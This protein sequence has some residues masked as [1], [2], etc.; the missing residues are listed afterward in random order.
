MPV[1]STNA[2]G[3]S[4]WAIDDPVVRLREWGGTRAIEL[5]AL[6]VQ[7]VVGAAP[8]C[9]VVL[10][11]PAGRVSRRHAM[12]ERS[13]STWTLRDLDSRNGIHQ[14]G[15][16]RTAFQLTPGTEVELGDLRF[17]ADSNRLAKLRELVQRLVGFSDDRGPDVDRVLAAVRSMATQRAALVLCGPGDL[18]PIARRLHDHALRGGSY[19]LVTSPAEL[20]RLDAK[21]DG[22]VV[23]AATALPPAFELR[24]ATRMPGARLRVI[25]LATEP[26]QLGAAAASLGPTATLVL[27]P[28]SDRRG[29]IFKL[30]RAYADDAVIAFGL[31][32]PSFREHERTWLDRLEP[33]THAELATLAER[34]VALRTWGV[35]AGAERLGISHVALLRWAQR[36]KIP[37]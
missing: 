10:D 36:R 13:G 11:D 4:G 29:E 24:M 8:E 27:T 28:L 6:P 33:D 32:G 30:I 5:A 15:E 35:T 21:R 2:D 26:D 37:T 31:D 3:S 16:R 9:D 23:V 18:A 1:A 19:A 34:L 20:A 12:L 22:T 25:V 14:D 17:V 7:A